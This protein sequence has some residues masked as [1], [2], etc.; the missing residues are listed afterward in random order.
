MTTQTATVQPLTERNDPMFGPLQRKLNQTLMI[1][2][3]NNDLMSRAGN[4]VRKSTVFYDGDGD[5]VTALTAAQWAAIAPHRDEFLQRLYA[6]TP[7][8]FYSI[9]V[10]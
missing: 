5:F 8:R 3:I 7:V 1:R 6:A 2:W 4:D 9:G 10:K